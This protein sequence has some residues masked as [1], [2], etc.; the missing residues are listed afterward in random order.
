[1]NNTLSSFG[2]TEQHKTKGQ[3]GEIRKNHPRDG[4]L[5]ASNQARTLDILSA[6]Y[7]GGRGNLGPKPSKRLK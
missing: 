5:G 1:M 6:D 7:H 4:S 3:G 2:G